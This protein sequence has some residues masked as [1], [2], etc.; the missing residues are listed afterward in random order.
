[1]PRHT[2]RRMVRGSKPRYVWVPGRDNENATVSSV[3]ITGDL[4]T[5]YVADAA[6]E[7]G[8]GMVI[9]RQIGWLQVESQVTG[10]GGDFAFGIMLGPEGGIAQNPL[11]QSEIENWIVTILG[12]FPSGANEQAAGVFQPDQAEY[13]WDVKTRRRFDKMGQE[14]IGFFH[15]PNS[16]SCLWSVQTRTL[17]RVT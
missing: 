5:A 9:E 11:V 1:M 13:K 12:A 8:P 16:T 14:M 6:R 15:N 10:S 3:G 7:T 2:G 17:V 4:L